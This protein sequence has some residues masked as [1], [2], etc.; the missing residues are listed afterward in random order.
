MFN[1]NCWQKGLKFARL[2]CQDQD[3]DFFPRAASRPRP[4]SRGLHL[5]PVCPLN[6]ILRTKISP[7]VEG[8]WGRCDDGSMVAVTV[9]SSTSL[10]RLSSCGCCCVGPMSIAAVVLSIIA[11][12][13]LSL[14]S[15]YAEN[16]VYNHLWHDVR[17]VEKVKRALNNIH[18]RCCRLSVS[19]FHN[20]II[21]SVLY[22][23][24]MRCSV[25][26]V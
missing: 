19:E 1:S 9:G 3:Q 7:W 17:V 20:R 12:Y 13:V 26:L 24:E 18:R 14:S 8:G 16:C 21:E 5:C 11:E 10:S 25:T 2:F 23:R 22:P 15:S 4:W 6:Y